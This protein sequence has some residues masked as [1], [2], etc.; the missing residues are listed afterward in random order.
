MRPS[1][2]P[3]IELSFRT[4]E[5]FERSQHRCQLVI[6]RDLVDKAEPS[7]NV[8]NA[9]WGGEL[10]YRMDVLV[11]GFHSGVRN[12]ESSEVNISFTKLQFCW[13]EHDAIASNELNVFKYPPPVCFNVRVPF[14]CIVCALLYAFHIGDNFVVASIEGVSTNVRSL[15]RDKIAIPPPLSNEGR[16]VSVLFSKWH[17]VEPMS[18]VCDGFPHIRWDGSS[19]VERGFLVMGLS[20]AGFVQ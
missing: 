7:S 20:Q 14:D 13:V 4:Q 18:G 1:A 19:L 8:R 17:R 2:H 9:F 3:S 11:K 12:I 6:V 16:V 15:W 10:S 5:R